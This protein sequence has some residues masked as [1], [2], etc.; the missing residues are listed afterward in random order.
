[1]PDLTTNELKIMFEDFNKRTDEK[2]AD[3]AKKSD[4]RHNEY[5]EE[6]KETKLMLQEI[7]NSLKTIKDQHSETEKN[8]ALLMEWSAEAKKV[9]EANSASIGQLQK[10]DYMVMGAFFVLSAIGVTFVTL[11]VKDIVRKVIQEE[12]EKIPQEVVRIL[13]DTYNL[14]IKD[15]K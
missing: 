5:K 11:Y 15:A 8:I 9:I 6:R 4:E 10:R 2:F 7:N 3:M 13:E 1:M 12:K 14:D